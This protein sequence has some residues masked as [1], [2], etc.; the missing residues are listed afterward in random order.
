[1]ATPIVIEGLGD[2]RMWNEWN[3]LDLM[4]NP[5]ERESNVNGRGHV[6]C[7]GDVFVC[8]YA[9]FTAVYWCDVYCILR[10]L[11]YL[12]PMSVLLFRVAPLSVVGSFVV[13]YD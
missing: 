5:V 11:L 10:T 6:D 7:F 1:M 9:V 12:W 13:Y 2:V 8:E 3:G 4:V